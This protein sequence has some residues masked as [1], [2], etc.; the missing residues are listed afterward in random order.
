MR[1]RLESNVFVD[2]RDART[3]VRVRPVDRV[4][5]TVVYSGRRAFGRMLLGGH[6]GVNY[7]AFGQNTPEKA[8]EDTD[9]ALQSEVWRGSVN[10]TFPA[11]M[12]QCYARLSETEA[13]TYTL[14]EVGL[15]VNALRYGVIVPGGYPLYGGTLFARALITPIA[16][17][18]TIVVLVYWLVP[19][20]AE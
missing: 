8:V 19:C 15:F 10:R 18:N 7:L 13:N 12:L 1:L 9:T 6:A 16:K 2:V 17:D 4:H 3:G 20:Y 14:R 11:G 5:N